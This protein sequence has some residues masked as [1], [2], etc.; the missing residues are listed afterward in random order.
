MKN[1]QKVRCGYSWSKGGGTGE[2]WACFAYPR[3]I[4]IITYDRNLN[5]RA[6]RVVPFYQN[7]VLLPFY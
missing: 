5:D 7:I 2:P 1:K 3:F 6:T 4:T